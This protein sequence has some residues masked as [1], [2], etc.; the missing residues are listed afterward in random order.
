MTPDEFRR[1]WTPEKLRLGTLP[2]AFSRDLAL[3]LEAVRSEERA[4]LQTTLRGRA[5]CYRATS[6]AC[7]EDHPYLRLCAGFAAEELENVVR[8]LGPEPAVE[9]EKGIGDA[10]AE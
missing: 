8:S 4:A 1:R 7:D 3:L 2:D 5:L 9:G 6:A 10:A